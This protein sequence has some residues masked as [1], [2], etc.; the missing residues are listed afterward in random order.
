MMKCSC[1]F[2]FPEDYM[3]DCCQKWLAIA[4]TGCRQC[5]FN[6]YISRPDL[7]EATIPIW[8]WRQR[9]CDLTQKTKYTGFKN[10]GEWYNCLSDTFMKLEFV[11]SV[12]KTGQVTSIYQGTT[13][14]ITGKLCDQLCDQL[15]VPNSDITKAQNPGLGLREAMT[16]DRRIICSLII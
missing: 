10:Q 4:S 5:T 11:K 3:L 6:C 15:R 16:K 14:L 8:T 1:L 7:Y 13:V 2:N 12:I 9:A